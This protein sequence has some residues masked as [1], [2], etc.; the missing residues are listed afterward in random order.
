MNR[1]PKSSNE[2]PNWAPPSAASQASPSGRNRKSVRPVTT[3]GRS[4][5]EGETTFP[6]VSPLV[7]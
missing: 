3:G 5:A 6:P 4:G 1:R 2:S 7:R